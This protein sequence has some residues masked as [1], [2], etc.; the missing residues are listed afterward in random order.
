MTE[1][2]DIPELMKVDLAALLAAASV[3]V[4]GGVVV[5]PL[6]DAEQQA[7]AISVVEAGASQPEMYAPI[8]HARIQVRCVAPRLVDAQSLGRS[9]YLAW[10]QTN[11]RLATITANGN[12]YLIHGSTCV[13]GP[14]QHYDTQET[15]EYL[16]F[17]SVMVGTQHT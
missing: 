1:P 10:H 8:I 11:R 9:V 2:I 7:G 3:T 13:A 12:T 5:G 15:W 4:P 14:S 17:F 16:L 6:T